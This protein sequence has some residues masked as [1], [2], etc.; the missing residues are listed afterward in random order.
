MR[1]PARSHGG[2]DRA[3]ID[4]CAPGAA[5]STIR[6]D[7]AGGRDQPRRF[8][9]VAW[10]RQPHPLPGSRAPG[11]CRR[12]AC[13]VAPASRPRMAKPSASGSEVSFVN[14]PLPGGRTPARAARRSSVPG[15]RGAHG[16][17]RQGGRLGPLLAPARIGARS[18]ARD[19]PSGREGEAGRAVRRQPREALRRSVRWKRRAARP[20]AASSSKSDDHS[21]SASASGTYPPTSRASCSSSA[22]S[23]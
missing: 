5:G 15:P 3:C 7:G 9:R 14:P 22:V 8:R 10:G 13:P 23:A 16:R 19:A 17:A 21:G 20:A 11:T 12:M 2:A 6:S 1:R 18:R 4:G